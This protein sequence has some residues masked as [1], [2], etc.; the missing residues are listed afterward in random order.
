MRRRTLATVYA[1]FC[2]LLLLG[3]SLACFVTAC[4][5]G[6]TAMAWT[7]LGL[8]LGVVFAPIGR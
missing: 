5:A 4:F 8:A 1:V 3:G 6:A 2:T 7:V